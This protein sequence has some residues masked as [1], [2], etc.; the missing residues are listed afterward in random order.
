MKDS[1]IN[2]KEIA[3]AKGLKSTRSLRLEINKPESKYISREVKVNGGTSYEIL[4]SSLE[5]ELQEKLRSAKN[6]YRN[7][8][9]VLWVIF[10]I[11]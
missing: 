5:P 9:A 1:Y 6:Y 4:F 7:S 2:I 8:M 10:I 3:E 11:S